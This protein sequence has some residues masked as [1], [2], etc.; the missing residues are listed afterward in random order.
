[1]A[2]IY[3]VQVVLTALAQTA[4]YPNGTG[5]PSI[6]GCD[7]KIFPGYPIPA[8]LDSDL[9]ARNAQVSIVP[10]V[11]K[12]S[13]RFD[14]SWQTTSINVATLILTIDASQSTPTSTIT[15]TGTVTTPQTCMVIVN[16]IAYAYG[17]QANDTINTIASSIADMIAGASALNN[18]ITITNAYHLAARISVS[19]TS[20]QELARERRELTVTVWAPT[21]IVRSQIGNALIVT[22][23]SSPRIALPDGYYAQLTFNGS[24]ESDR[25]EKTKCYAREIN[26][27][28]D[29]AIT[30]TETDYTVA[31]TINNISSVNSI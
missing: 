23:A 7:V 1:M 13:T 17:V 30:N 15:I 12:M 24:K 14:K 8:A 9:T 3:D 19:G 21:P 29:Y 4:I 10:G 5:S 16:D 20:V 28:V 25:M 2:D 6:S 31:E 26:F 18:V 27:S 22:F 11:A